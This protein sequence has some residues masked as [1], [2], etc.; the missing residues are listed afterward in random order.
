MAYIPDSAYQSAG[1]R[2]GSRSSRR[3]FI[4]MPATITATVS[5]DQ[6]HTAFIRDISPHGMFFYSNLRLDEGSRVEFVLEYPNRGAAARLHLTGI[7]RRV[8]TGRPGSAVG[9]AIQ[10]D[11]HHDEFP[12]R[13]LH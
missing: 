3:T 13:L 12:R 2:N 11:E 6:V 10:F 4:R 1:F 5:D 9:I 8:E 7:V